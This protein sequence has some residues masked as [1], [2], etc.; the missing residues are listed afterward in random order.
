MTEKELRKYVKLIKKQNDR[1]LS[2]M[3]RKEKIE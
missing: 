2:T 1:L 3:D